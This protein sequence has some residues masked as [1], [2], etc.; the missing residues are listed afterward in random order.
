MKVKVPS[1]KLLALSVTILALLQFVLVG[2][3]VHHGSENDSR[4][5]NNYRNDNSPTQAH[6]L[7]KIASK[8]L[9]LPGVSHGLRPGG[10]RKA[11][12]GQQAR[13]QQASMKK[14]QLGG[15]ARKIQAK[16]NNMKK[17]PPAAAN[18][19]F[20]Y[21]LGWKPRKIRKQLQPMM[22][23]TPDEGINKDEQSENL[24]DDVEPVDEEPPRHEMPLILN[25]HIGAS[26]VIN[27]TNQ[28]HTLLHNYTN[29]PFPLKI[30]SPVFVASLLKSGTTSM[31]QYFQCGGHKANHQWFTDPKTGNS[32]QTGKCIRDNV[33][34]HR[35]PFDGCGDFDIYTDTGFANY[36]HQTSEC[37]YPSVDA[38]EAIYEHYPQATIMFV[39]RNTTQWY[40]SMKSWGKGSLLDRW[41]PC[42][43]THF[44]SFTARK[45]DF[46][47]FY[48]W[49]SDSLRIFC[50]R[51]TSLNCIEVPLESHETGRILEERVGI[52]ST[53][54]AKCTPTSRL[55]EP[56]LQP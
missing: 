27:G 48:E 26:P 30:Q 8:T 24:N 2:L 16:R 1:K 55:C 18:S 35:P 49:H 23:K 51:H 56:V 10:N 5:E 32:T 34:A 46:L 37:Y 20:D 39:V 29:N 9:S 38:L 43:A 4:V 11:K 22:K 6:G 36:E 13:V 19:L 21:I 14:K 47:K 3:Y 17:K 54:W 45:E 15:W 33:R 44:P 52:P 41:R 12:N 28:S 31:W 42:N 50:Q 40:K 25:H 53:C 7:Q